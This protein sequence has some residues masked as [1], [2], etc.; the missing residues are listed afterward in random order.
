[1]T[2]GNDNGKSGPHDFSVYTLVGVGLIIAGVITLMDGTIDTVDLAFI[3]L[4]EIGLVLLIAGVYTKKS[5]YYIAGTLVTAIGLGIP[6]LIQDIAWLTKQQ[7]IGLMIAAFSI[8]WFLIILLNRVVLNKVTYWQILP[9]ITGIFI[10]AAFLLTSLQVMEIVFFTI[11]GT[12]VALLS[13]GILTRHLGLIIPGGLLIGIGP[14]IYFPW[15]GSGPKNGLSQTG[16][17]LVWF[18]FG[19]A[20]IVIASKLAMHKF[21]WWPLIPG[22]VLAVVG[23]G[24]YIGG[25]PGNALNFLGNSGSI[26]LILIGIYLLMMRRGLYR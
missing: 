18:A 9:G 13:W 15:F 2:S 23:W 17:M 3:L 24:L 25:N 4:P 6:L 10:A 5:G 20:L 26:L 14:G 22:G 16:T 1:M 11:L 8:G 7:K 12:G 19:W 21:V